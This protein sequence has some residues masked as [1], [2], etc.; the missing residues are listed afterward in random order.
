[1]VSVVGDGAT[2][3]QAASVASNRALWLLADEF[4]LDPYDAGFVL[5]AA[6][7]LRVC[8]YLP[9]Y[10]SVCR[11][12]IPLEVLDRAPAATETGELLRGGS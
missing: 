12:D 2:L 7:H 1:M 6:C 4:G 5:S 8:R 9:N 11:I 3:D 10:G